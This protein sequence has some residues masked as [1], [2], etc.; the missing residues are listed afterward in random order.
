MMLEFVRSLLDNICIQFFCVFTP[1]R[2]SSSRFLKRSLVNAARKLLRKLAGYN[3]KKRLQRV[4]TEFIIVI[5][6]FLEAVL[7]H[8]ALQDDSEHL[9]LQSVIIQV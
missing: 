5:H 4:E 9:V 7:V 6:D 3:L 1:V 2:P 8:E